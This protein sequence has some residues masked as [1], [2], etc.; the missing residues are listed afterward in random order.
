MLI[1]YTEENPQQL[2]DS[3]LGC[4]TPEEG[5]LSNVRAACAMGLSEIKDEVP[6]H[7]NRAIICGGGPSLVGSLESIHEMKARGGTIFAL[8]NVA[9]FLAE[10]GI[11]ADYQVIIDPREQNKAFVE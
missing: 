3:P 1:R 8:N 4:N 2:I 7:L 10:N 5:L 6:A 9:R 11:R